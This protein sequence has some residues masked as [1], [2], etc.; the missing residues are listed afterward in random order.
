M[1]Q[2]RALPVGTLGT[3]I[4]LANQTGIAVDRNNTVWITGD[5]E[6]L[7]IPPSGVVR[8]F[9]MG[10]RGLVSSTLLDLAV[11]PGG[12][13]L[14]PGVVDGFHG[15]ILGFPDNVQASWGQSFQR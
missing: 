9:A 5:L 3:G 15:C 6:M 14:R 1:S 10:K 4:Q 8:Y 7:A 2:K 11:F 12:E 13:L